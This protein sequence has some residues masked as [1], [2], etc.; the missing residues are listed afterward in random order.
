MR[1]GLEILVKSL[2]RF[3]S[4]HKWTGTLLALFFV[5]SALTGI[6][7]A[8][9]KEVRLLQPPTQKGENTSMESWLPLSTIDSLARIALIQSRP[10]QHSNTIDRMDIR[11]SKRV[12]KVLFKKGN[13]EVQIDPGNGKTLSVAR[14]HSDWIEALH[15]GSIISNSFK[16]ISMNAIGWGLI[17]LVGSGLWLWYGPKAIR[18][19]KKRGGRGK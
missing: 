19:I 18:T 7:L 12:V 15:D 13:W 6:L 1:K 2:R 10:E 9:K 17:F 14:R 3:R 16:L 5:I 8:L 4:W 11:P